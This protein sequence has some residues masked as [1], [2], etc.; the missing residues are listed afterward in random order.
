MTRNHTSSVHK[1][2]LYD[3]NLLEPSC[4]EWAWIRLSLC[5]RLFGERVKPSIPPLEL[6]HGKLTF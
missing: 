5:E 6:L 2:S 1:S 4:V 3:L